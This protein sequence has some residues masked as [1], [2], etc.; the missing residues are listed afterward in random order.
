MVF[1]DY[2]GKRKHRR[3]TIA[4]RVLK[5]EMGIYSDVRMRSNRKFDLLY[6]H[7]RSDFNGVLLADIA[8]FM[9]TAYRL[10][11]DSTKRRN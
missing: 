8:A 9:D 2:H 11:C 1:N 4:V 3:D 5:V 7:D 10:L 6:T